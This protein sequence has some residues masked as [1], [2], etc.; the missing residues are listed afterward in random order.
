[1]NLI[2]S[3]DNNWGIGYRG[4]LLFCIP[5]DMRYFKRMT[6]NKIVIMGSSTLKSLP[7]AKP[8]LNRVN[9]VLSKNKA[10]EVTGVIICDSLAQ[11]SVAINN[12]NTDDIFVIGGQI[13]YAQLLNC[14]ATTY[15]TKVLT[16]RD[17]D[18]YFPNLDQLQ[19]WR[20]ISE[21]EVK[22]HNDIPYTFC[23]Y[24]NINP[25]LSIC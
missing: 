17:A 1:M 23:I 5:E 21:S 10:P 25:L 20:M 12:Y 13:V 19:N 11:L 6:E 15:V 7:G 3:V 24:H 4:Q 2:V 9:I 8:L 18:V 16:S 22:Y 14:C